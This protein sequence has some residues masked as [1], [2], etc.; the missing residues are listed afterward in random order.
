MK[1]L[2]IS[3]EVEI[4]KVKAHIGIAGNE[5]ADELAKEATILSKQTANTL[6]LT[7]SQIIIAQL[8]YNKK[9]GHKIPAKHE[10]PALHNRN[11]AKTNRA[12]RGHTAEK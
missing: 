12:E 11:H 3:N 2:Q 4:I 6:P 9:N 7:K 5:K 8:S 10:L 1:A